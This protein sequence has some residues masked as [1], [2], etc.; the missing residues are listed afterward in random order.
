MTKKLIEKMFKSGI[1]IKRIN[2]RNGYE[3]Y[4]GD[5]QVNDVIGFAK[6][7]GKFVQDPVDDVLYLIINDE[8]IICSFKD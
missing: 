1:P 6:F 2:T 4:I 7:G 3:D 8:D 5:I